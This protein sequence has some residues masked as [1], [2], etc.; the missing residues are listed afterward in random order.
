MAFPYFRANLPLRTVLEPST[1]KHDAAM[2]MLEHLS[3]S[4]CFSILNDFCSLSSEPGSEL[5]VWHACS[6]MSNSS[7]PHGLVARQAPLSME[8]SSKNPGV[9]CH[10]LLQGIF[11][12]RGSNSCLL[13]WQAY[14]LPLHHQGR[15]LSSLQ[16]KKVLSNSIYPQQGPN[17]SL[18]K[19]KGLF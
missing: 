2:V 14:S 1:P 6:V 18:H 13:H 9:G 11:P 16:A 12:T 5:L 8:F 4:T 3:N 17:E 10:F 7:W 15:P 19:A